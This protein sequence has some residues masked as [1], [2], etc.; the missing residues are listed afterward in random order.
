MFRDQ[1]GEMDKENEQARKQIVPNVEKLIAK[2]TPILEATI[3]RLNAEPIVVDVNE[4]ADSI[5]TAELK[6]AL[7]KLGETD[8]AKI[9]I[10]DELTK[11]VVKNIV[12][13]PPNDSKKKSESSK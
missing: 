2:E 12:S 13:V 1:I 5:R 11:N 8:E 9:K 10:I 7:E 3:N 4:S 6:K